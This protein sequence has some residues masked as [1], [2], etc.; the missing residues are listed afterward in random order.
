MATRF[1]LA[2]LAYVLP[3]F[4]I[5]YLWHLEI[6]R[7]Y[8]ASLAVYRPDIIIPFGIAS[9]LIQGVVWAYIYSRLF[10]HE[11]VVAGAIKFAAL[12]TPLGWSYM[13]LAVS[14]KHHMS[15]VSG[16]LVIESAFIVVH[17]A[18]VSPLIALAF[19]YRRTSEAVAT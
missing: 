14:A 2:I 7:H 13:V 8:Y 15:S 4:P 16:F 12:A 17:Y 1:L 9:M 11:S 18:V 19:S 5:G 3:T 6:F 10:R